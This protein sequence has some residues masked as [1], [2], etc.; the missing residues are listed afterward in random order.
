MARG[1]RGGGARDRGRRRRRARAPGGGA[2]RRDGVP[3]GRRGGAP[4]GRRERAA[5]GRAGRRRRRRRGSSASPATTRACSPSASRPGWCSC[6]TR[7]G[8]R[9][10]RR[11][12]STST[13]PRSA[14]NALL[15]R[16]RAA[17]R[18]TRPYRLPAMANVHSH[19]FQ[20]DLRGIGERPAPEAHAGDDFWSWR[21]A[22][23]ALAGRHDPDSMREAR[24][25]R[26]R[27]DGG[28]R[29]RRGRR[30]PLRPPPARTAARTTTR[31]RWRSR[32]PRP[33]SRPGWPS[34][35]SPPP[36][37]AAGWDPAAAADRRPA[38]LLRPD[39][40]GVPRARRRA[41]RLGGAARARV[42]RG[43]RPQRPRGAGAV[44]G[45]DRRLRG[46]ARPRPP[47]PRPRAAA[48]AGGVP[49]RVRLLAGRAAGA[50]RLPRPAD[51]AR[52]RHPRRARRHRAAGRDSDTIVASCPT[53]EGNLGDGH[54]PALAYRDAGV[55]LAHRVRQPGGG[56]SVRGDPGAG[57]R[58]RGA[59]GGPA[60]RCWRA[61]GDLWGELCRAGLREPRDRHR[62]HVEID[63]DHPPFAGCSRR[64]RRRWR[65]PP[66]RRP[67]SLSHPR[68]KGQTR[69]F[70]FATARRRPPRPADP[71]VPDAARRAGRVRSSATRSSP[72]RSRSR[73]STSSTGRPASS[74][75]CSPPQALPLAIL[76][77]AAGVW[78]DRLPRQRIMLVSDLGRAVGPGGRR[79]AADRGHRRAVD[80]GRARRALR[81]LRGRLPS[82]RPA[83][84]SPQ[85]A[86]PEHLQQ[87]NALM[88]MA[89]NVG[90]RARAEPRRR[91]DRGDRP[92][93][94]DRRRRGHLRG[95]RRLPASPMR[96]PPPAPREDA[97]RAR[98]LLGRAARR[99]RR[100]PQAPLD[101]VVHA[102]VH[103]L[104]PARAARRARA[105]AGDRRPR[106][107]RRVELGHDRH[108]LRDRHD[109]R[110]P[111]RR[112]ACAPPRPMYAVHRRASSPRRASR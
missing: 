79:R 55:R 32:S 92:R 2:Q 33:R 24:R 77:L 76:V 83:G 87:A 45:G 43:R 30:V 50:H 47:R 67:T 39:R 66:A 53:T 78:A 73:C 74:G 65:S 11:R 102:R 72:S 63:L 29:L 36:T 71:A 75:S 91:A 4:R 99:R 18:M 98:R 88:G 68:L 40:R 90:A 20:R 26:V 25:A 85:V 34:S 86:G 27:G 6:A 80:A 93:A 28:G 51:H 64:G 82:R 5:R 7:P 42:G 62:G 95:Q 22:M 46:R 105:R 15:R 44:A 17:G 69:A 10:R 84:W 110:R 31:T 57:D 100:G 96:P 1:L 41:A 54:L 56:R 8:S 49:R 112:C 9:T 70:M 48:R 104:P 12:T 35:C 109:P 23:Y 103:E 19:A 3:R 21:E 97:E 101:V 94:G 58:S 61:A 52:P 13:T 14:A 59:S 16:R 107:G 89:E 106:A 81:H 111:R 38:A 60:T 108:L 37:T